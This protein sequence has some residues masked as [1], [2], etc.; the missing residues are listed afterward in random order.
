MKPLHALADALAILAREGWTPPDCNVPDLARQVRELEAQ[1]A[2]TG[3]ELHAAED[4]LSLCMPDGSNA[5]LVRWLRLQRRATSSR[6]QLAT[7]NTAEV[8]LRSELERQVWQAQHRRAEGSTRA[9]AA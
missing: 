5:T 9:A 4:A 8:Y 6:L 3:E 2:R 1:Q 7:L